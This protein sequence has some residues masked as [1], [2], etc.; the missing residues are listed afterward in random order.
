VSTDCDHGNGILVTPQTGSGSHGLI[1]NN[2]SINGTIV[3]NGPFSIVEGNTV[4]G[5]GCGAGIVGGRGD[6]QHSIFSNNIITGGRHSAATDYPQGIQNWMAWSVINGNNIYNNDGAPIS[7]G[8]RYSLVLGNNCTGNGLVDHSGISTLYLDTTY[9]GSYSVFAANLSNNNGGGMQD[10]GY[11]E[12]G[13]ATHIRQIGNNYNG[14][15]IGQTN[16][17][18][19]YPEANL[20]GLFHSEA[21]SPAP[22]LITDGSSVSRTVTVP[23]AALGDFVDA[24]YSVNLQGVSL[25]GSVT[26]PSLVTL[27]MEN[28]TGG[29]KTIGVGTVSC[30][31]RKGSYG[32]NNY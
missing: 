29:Q 2:T 23:G 4:T 17:A 20:P 32:N 3:A 28:H 11:E 8:G 27:R 1:K 14:N 21:W 12:T 7:Q 31:V 15:T 25:F 6:G 19:A 26:S 5:F 30:V 24:S 16:S 10:Y 13:S 18:G 9:N 22:G